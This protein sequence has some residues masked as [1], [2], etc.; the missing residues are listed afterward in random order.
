M[1][2]IDPHRAAFWPA[3][4]ALAA[5]SSAAGSAK[6]QSSKINLADLPAIKPGPTPRQPL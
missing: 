3:A 4:L 5:Q 2:N 1:P 6:A